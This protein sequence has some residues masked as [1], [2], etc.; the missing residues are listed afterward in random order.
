MST[1]VDI[2]LYSIIKKESKNNLIVYKFVDEFFLS[3][4]NNIFIYF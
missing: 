3:I 1:R 2:V 4:L